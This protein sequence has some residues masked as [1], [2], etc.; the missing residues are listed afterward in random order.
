MFGFRVNWQRSPKSQYGGVPSK[1]MLERCE[2]RLVFGKSGL[3][4]DDRC[5]CGTPHD[6][7]T[8]EGGTPNKGMFRFCF[9]VYPTTSV[10]GRPRKRG[11]HTHTQ[12][13]KRPQPARGWWG[14][15]QRAQNPRTVKLSWRAHE[16]PRVFEAERPLQACCEPTSPKFCALSRVVFFFSVRSRVRVRRTNRTCARAIHKKASIS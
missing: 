11:Q 7:F 13:K 14:G 3:T 15:Q 4:N 16:T 8:L 12:K 5:A 9:T 10:P 1:T 6:Y 2:L